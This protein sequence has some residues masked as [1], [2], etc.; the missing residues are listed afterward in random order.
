VRSFSSL[1]QLSSSHCKLISDN[2]SSI[3]AGDSPNKCPQSDNTGV[4]SRT[5]ETFT[6]TEI[7]LYSLWV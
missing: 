1:S 2:V 6:T 5:C 7:N 3:T 4:R